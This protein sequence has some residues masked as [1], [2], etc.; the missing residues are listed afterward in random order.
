MRIRIA[1][2]TAY[3][4]DRPVKA[5]IQTLRLTPRAHDGQ[6][7]LAWRVE[8]DGAARLSPGEDALGNRLHVLSAEGTLDSL[9]VRVE[10]EVEMLDTHG[11][12]R[13]AVE[14]FPETVFLRE[15]P[16]TAPDEAL[17]AFAD[18]AA[19]RGTRDRL[20]LLH[21]LLEAIHREMTFDTEPTHAATTAAEAFAL[22]R[23]V[24]Q[25]LTHVFLAAC[26]HLGIPARYVSGYFLRG[27][28]VVVQEAGHAWA[29]AYVPALG[30]VGF[31]AANG[32][33]PTDAHV[34]VA[35]G[36]DYLGAAPVRGART[37]GGAEA[38]SVSLRIEQAAWQT[39]A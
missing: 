4:Y 18:A 31:D 16:L 28:G 12:V 29:E 20:A 34:R 7:I 5:V 27:D 1:H 35:I 3:H 37:G 14:R 15:T 2:V 36:L 6:H 11:V 39:Q 21:H 24:C 9:G 38:L 22:R 23:G 13:G 30:W 33:S 17:C 26:R 25:D 19:S 8:V 32:I 10:G